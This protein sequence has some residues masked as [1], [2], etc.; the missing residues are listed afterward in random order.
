MVVADADEA[1]AVVEGVTPMT[2]TSRDSS[3]FA[4]VGVVAVDAVL[5]VLKDDCVVDAV[6][7]V[8]ALEVEADCADGAATVVGK[9]GI[10]GVATD[11]AALAGE[12]AGRDIPEEADT[13]ATTVVVMVVV[14]TAACPLAMLLW[15]LVLVLVTDE[16]G[17]AAGTSSAIATYTSVTFCAC[18][19]GV[20]VG[21][22]SV[23]VLDG[24]AT[25]FVV[26]LLFVSRRTFAPTHGAAS[27][28]LLPTPGEFSPAAIGSIFP[29]NGS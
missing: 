5:E 6:V 15:G 7:A 18:C 21:A 8:V 9:D 10:E 3:A 16:F 4:G 27:L 12:R 19:E 17:D 25:P 20:A 22:V 11:T 14:T 26:E 1:P 29:L 23:A 2:S 28:V 24:L 13:V